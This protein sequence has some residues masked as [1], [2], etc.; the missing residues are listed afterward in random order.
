M[1]CAKCGCELVTMRYHLYGKDYCRTCALDVPR[2]PDYTT[3]HV[4]GMVFGEIKTPYEFHCKGGAVKKG[5]FVDDEQAVKWFK[6]TYPELYKAG[7]EM[8][9]F[10]I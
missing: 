7:A 8:R 3:E 10:D 2:K 9:V 5:Y 6:E 1:N 4:N